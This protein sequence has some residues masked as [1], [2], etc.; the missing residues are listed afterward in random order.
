MKKIGFL[1]SEISKII[2][3]LGHTDKIVICDS[4]LPIPTDVNE[5]IWRLRKASP[6]PEL[7]GEDAVQ[8]TVKVNKG[9]KVETFIPTDLDL[10]TNK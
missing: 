4:G 1:N 5:L 6:L 3:E 7:I 2:S 9:E 10:I 8:T